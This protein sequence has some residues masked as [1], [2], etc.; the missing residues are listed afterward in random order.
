MIATV[1]PQI[2][3]LGCMCKIYDQ[4]GNDVLTDYWQRSVQPN[5]EE[6]EEVN[7]EM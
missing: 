6:K 3:A 5:V 7:N 2:Y 1:I 4:N